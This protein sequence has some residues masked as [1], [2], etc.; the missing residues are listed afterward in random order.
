[1]VRVIKF[2]LMSILILIAASDV[3]DANIFLVK[4]IVCFTILTFVAAKM[5]VSEE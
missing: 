4:S 5:I 1:M 2:L 3:E